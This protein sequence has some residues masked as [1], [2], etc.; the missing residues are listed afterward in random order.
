MNCLDVKTGV[1]SDSGIRGLKA[2]D[3]YDGETE[4]EE[5]GGRQDDCYLMQGTSGQS[6]EDCLIY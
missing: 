2:G 6:K 1:Y 4:E 3:D 5:G